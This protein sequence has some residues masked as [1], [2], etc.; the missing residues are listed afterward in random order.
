MINL[1]KIENRYFVSFYNANKLNVLNSKEIESQLISV[2]KNE[3]SHMTLNFAGVEFIDSSGFDVLRN[4]YQESIN[5][6]SEI[7]FL[8]LSDDLIELVRLVELDKVFQIN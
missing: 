6:N 4:I 7:E 2:V 5:T 8:N 3:N 1:D